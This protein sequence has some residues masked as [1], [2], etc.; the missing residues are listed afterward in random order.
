MT[1]SLVQVFVNFA[2]QQTAED[3][4]ITL[5]RRTGGGRKDIKVSPVKRKK[6]KNHF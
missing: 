6:W 4:D 1:L 3:E 2:K 5:K